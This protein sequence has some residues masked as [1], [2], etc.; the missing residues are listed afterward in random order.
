M[1]FTI[2]FL[3]NMRDRLHN[4]GAAVI[5]RNGGLYAQKYSKIR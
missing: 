2:T 3:M 1:Q 5:L 4:T